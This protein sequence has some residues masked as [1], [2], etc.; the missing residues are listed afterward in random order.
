MTPLPASVWRDPYAEYSRPPMRTPVAL[1]PPDVY[2]IVDTAAEA[3]HVTADE[4]LGDSRTRPLY[5]YR[6]ITMAACRQLT[7]L[8][9]PAIGD[10]FGRDHSTVMHAAHVVERNP[11]M[12]AAVAELIRR[13]T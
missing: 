4:L 12:R 6:Q 11:E 2:D 3:F 8:S 1:A 7:D 10:V 5:R 9:Y 13:V